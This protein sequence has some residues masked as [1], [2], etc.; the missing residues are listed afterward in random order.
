MIKF[1]HVSL[2]LGDFSLCDVSL[3]IAQG[4]VF[5]ILGPTGAG[6]TIILE[7]I[8]GFY[9]PQAGCI[10]IQNKDV[11]TIPPEK[12]GIGFVYQDYALFP[13]LNVYKNIAFGL[14]LIKCSSSLVKEKV[15]LLSQMMGITH[16]WHR[17]PGTL[18]GG[19]QQRVALARALIVKPQI[20]L[21]DEPFSALDPSTKKT[22]YQ[23]VKKIHARI[24]CTIVHVTHDFTEV[25]AL[26]DRVG[27]ILDGKI[28]QVGSPEEIFC[29]PVDQRI[30]DFLGVEYNY[31]MQKVAVKA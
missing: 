13:H 30:A 17:Y 6:K 25:G 24:K 18:S 7:M 26:A 31:P 22:L 28:R 4:E 11:S 16:L 15:R 10:L 14:Q 21:I 2:G 19:E 29:R 20:L 9:R 27:I 23:E 3:E 1:S 8:A 12:R 5:S